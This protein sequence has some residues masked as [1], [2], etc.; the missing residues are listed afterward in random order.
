[1]LV[2][3][4]F[5]EFQEIVAWVGYLKLDHTFDPIFKVFLVEMFFL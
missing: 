1:M 4:G 5:E 2:T 3:S